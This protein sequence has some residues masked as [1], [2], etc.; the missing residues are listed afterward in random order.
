[1]TKLAEKKLQRS[2]PNPG[3]RSSLESSS[4]ALDRNINRNGTAD[5]PLSIRH[6]Y[7]ELYYEVLT[8]GSDGYVRRKRV[9]ARPAAGGGRHL[10]RQ[11]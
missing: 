10:P 6:S 11:E 9:L 8:S 5:L 3:N 1:M 7:A 2:D 4:S